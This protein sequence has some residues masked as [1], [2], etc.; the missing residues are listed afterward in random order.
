MKINTARDIIIERVGAKFHS[1]V[2]GQETECK[3]ENG[4]RAER[5]AQAELRVHPFPACVTFC[6]LTRYILY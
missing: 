3:T 4:E 2:P 1:L 6:L 5:A